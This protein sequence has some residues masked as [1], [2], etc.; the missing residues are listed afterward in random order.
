[1]I[2]RQAR[3]VSTTNKRCVFSFV[4]FL[5]RNYFTYFYF[6]FVQVTCDQAVAVAKCKKAGGR[7]CTSQELIDDCASGTGCEHD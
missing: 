5:F 2:A 4:F 7:L 6:V 3:A 1:M